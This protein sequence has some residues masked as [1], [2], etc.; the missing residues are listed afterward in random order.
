M[1]RGTQTLARFLN[2]LKSGSV[3]SSKLGKSDSSAITNL[4]NLG[5]LTKQKKGSGQIYVLHQSSSYLIWEKN[6]FPQGTESAAKSGKTRSMAVHT[7][8]DSKMSQQTSPFIEIRINSSLECEQIGSYFW[9][10]DE[11]PYILGKSVVLIENLR[12][13]LKSSSLFPS[14]HVAMRYDGII[15]DEIINVISKSDSKILIAPDYDPVGL[16]SYVRIKKILGDRIELFIPDDLEKLF[17]SYSNRSLLSS[18][19][20]NRQTLRNLLKGELDEDSLFVIELIQKYNAGL[21]QEV[22]HE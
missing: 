13:F 21:E 22:L 6:Y 10:Y 1:I 2:E 17:K 12:T 7:L 18:K 5:F 15:S 11:F 16:L 4:E 20:K 9:Y 8:R 19:P 3:P 14:Y